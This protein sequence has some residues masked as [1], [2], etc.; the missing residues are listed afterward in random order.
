M[1]FAVN[2]VKFL[3]TSSCIEHLCCQVILL[4]V[5]ESALYLM[6]VDA[7]SIY[8]SLHRLG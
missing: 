8:V 2:F 1:C 5:D 7:Q 3:R 6:L 4:V